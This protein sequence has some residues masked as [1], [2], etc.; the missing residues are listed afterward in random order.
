LPRS[1]YSSLDVVQISK[2]LLGKILVSHINETWTAGRIVE[3]EAYRAPDD[4]ACHA[5]NNRRTTRTET[6]FHQGGTAYIYLCYGIHHLFNVVTGPAEE[7][8]AVLIRGLEPIFG[9][10]QMLERRG[11]PKL[12]T[13]LSAG[14]GVLSQALGIKR[15]YDTCDLTQKTSPIWITADDFQLKTTEL[16]IGTRV[17]VAYA[18]EDAYRPWRFSI[19]NN[20]WVSKGQGLVRPTN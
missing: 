7:A 6:M 12:K 5:A 19:Q 1:F 15:Q 20:P 16:L 8:H 2:N 18:G 10:E 4:Q 14:P 11:L 13:Q 17:G 9:I 3:T